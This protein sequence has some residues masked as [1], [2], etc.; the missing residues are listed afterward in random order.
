MY[1]KVV[2]NS[3]RVVNAPVKLRTVY[4]FQGEIVKTNRG[5]SLEE[6]AINIER[7][8]Q[9][10]S[11]GATYVEVLDADTEQLYYSAKIKRVTEKG[12]FILK[13]DGIYEWNP[14]DTERKYGVSALFA[15]GKNGK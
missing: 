7:H 10:N 14:E 11:Y 15:K 13:K 1:K 3:G 6:A 12:K 8:V 4:M 5:T 2:M 9:R